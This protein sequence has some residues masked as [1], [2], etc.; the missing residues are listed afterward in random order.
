MATPP[1]LHIKLLGT[2]ELVYGDQALHTVNTRRLQSLL[3]YL[4]LRCTTPQHRQRIAF[5]FWPDSTEAQARTNL[6]RELHHLR[7]ALPDADAFL[8][9]DG[10]TVQWRPDAPY[11]LDVAAFEHAVDATT[12]ADAEQL[13]AAVVLYRGE[14]LP[15]CYDDWIVEER[16]RLSQKYLA[17]LDQLVAVME[18]RRDYWAAIRYA[19]QLLRLDPLHEPTYR[20]LMRLHALK[21]DRAGALRLYHTCAAVLQD[22][23]GVEPEAATRALYERLLHADTAVRP[24]TPPSTGPTLIGRQREWQQLHAAWQAAAAGRAQA[25]IVAGEAGIGKTRLA[26]ELLHHAAQGIAT[27]RSRAYA[28]EG[29]LAYAPVID[30]LRS[31][32][33]RTCW[34]RLDPI[35]LTELA[36]LLPELRTE[37]PELPR[38]EPLTENWQRRRL[39]EALA[40]ATLAASQPLLLLLDDLQWCDQ[41]TLEWLRYLL[42]FDPQAR[43]LIVGTLRMEEVEPDHAIYTLLRDLHQAEQVAEIVLGPLSDVETAALAAQVAGRTIEP[44]LAIT[45][46]HET[47]GHPLFVVEMMRAGMSQNSLSS[48]LHA[49]RSTPHAAL[50]PRIQTVITARLAQL[51]PEAHELASLA[52]TLGRAFSLVVLSQASDTHEDSLVRGLDELQQRQ[53]VREQSG[54]TYDFSHDKLR[55]VAYAQMS[56][57]RRRMLHRRAAEAL[58]HVHA[59]DL[60]A[61]SGQIAAHYERAGL[62][63]EAIP[64][65]QRAATVAQRV[66]ANAEAISFLQRGLAL[67]E[68]R[69]ASPARDA[70]ELALQTALGVSLVALKGYSALEAQTTYERA[71]MLGQQLGHPPNAPVLRALAITLVSRGEIRAA[72][73]LGMHLLEIARRTSDPIV[74]VEAQYVLGVTSFWFGEFAA[75]REHLEQAVQQYDRRQHRTHVTIYGQ[76]PCVVCL[77]RL[78]LTLWYLGY[79][80]QAVQHGQQALALAQ[81]LGHPLSWAYALNYVAWLSQECGDGP[82][83]QR[84]AEDVHRL[85]TQYQLGFWPATTEVLQGWMRVTQGD[86]AAGLVQMRRGIVA[87]RTSRHR[88]HLPYMLALLA[89]AYKLAG[90][91]RRGLAAIAR[92]TALVERTEEYFYKAE[93]LRIKGELLLLRSEHAGA[94][95]CFRHALAPARHQGAKALELRAATSLARLLQRQGRPAEAHKLLADVYGWFTEGFDTPDLQEA[96]TLLAS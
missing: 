48:T 54:D 37:R 21:D 5:L 93:L 65:Y 63:S 26:E 14:L 2:F 6:R 38:P 84:Q 91:A 27:A 89:Q 30:W 1:T 13:E 71:R 52:A 22:E 11:T 41:E 42:R 4:V 15:G 57:A 69:P 40:R 82:A 33:L 12:P 80:G 94:Q 36:R 61:V 51:S 32:A 47:E 8:H 86:A 64:Y 20:R 19:E 74:F 43:L 7:N 23:L 56:I 3:T 16:E 45:L 72:N 79:P 66:Y 53:I 70:Q 75:A 44:D 59:A 95:A 28:A 78:A 50:P 24:L 55:E 25:A 17:A 96:R 58:E 67:L 9:L 35:W 18:E 88:L 85:T 10:Q 92:A 60:D 73:H 87:H 62:A 31:V 77:S 29:R 49:P 83:A 81:E 76:D 39:F 68:T 90:D 34:A 46:Y